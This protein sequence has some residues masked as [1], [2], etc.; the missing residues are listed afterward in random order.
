[1]PCTRFKVLVSSEIRSSLKKP[2]AVEEQYQMWKEMVV[3]YVARKDIGPEIVQKVH[4]LVPNEEIAEE[5]EETA[6]EIEETDTVEEV[7]LEEEEEEEEED[8][9]QDQG[10]DHQ[11][12]EEK[13]LQEDPQDPGLL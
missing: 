7:H 5:T 1:M 11:D 2:R 3:L 12:E 8:Q 10:L 9:D 6:E 13:G 4:E